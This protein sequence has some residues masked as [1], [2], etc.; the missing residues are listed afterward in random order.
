MIPVELVAGSDFENRRGRCQ[1]K[2]A[3]SSFIYSLFGD[4]RVR[5]RVLSGLDRTRKNDE[6]GSTT[7]E[8]QHMIFSL[9]MPCSDI[10]TPPSDVAILIQESGFPNETE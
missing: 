10:E 8:F 5:S 2:L 4:F 9:T 1:I 7:G 6:T 3:W